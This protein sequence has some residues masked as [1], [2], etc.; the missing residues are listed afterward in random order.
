MKLMMKVFLYPE[1]GSDI[2]QNRYCQK[3][4]IKLQWIDNK[5]VVIFDN[6]YYVMQKF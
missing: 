3:L 6:N 5:A 1:Q 4:N 2:K